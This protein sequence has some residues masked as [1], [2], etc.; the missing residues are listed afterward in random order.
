MHIRHGIRDANPRPESPGDTRGLQE[1]S[2]G[3]LPNSSAFNLS[4]LDLR[5]KTKPGP[6]QDVLN[7]FSSLTMLGDSSPP[8]VILGDLLQR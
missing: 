4:L 7:G 5:E 3:N 2:G 8:W 6:R 1:A